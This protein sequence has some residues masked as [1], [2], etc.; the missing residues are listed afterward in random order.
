L[1]NAWLNDFGNFF[2]TADNLIKPKKQS[3]SVADLDFRAKTTFFK[4]SKINE[5]IL[6]SEKKFHVWIIHLTLSF[7]KWLSLETI[8]SNADSNLII[9]FTDSLEVVHHV[10]QY[11]FILPSPILFSLIN[12]VSLAL[13]WC[14]FLKYEANILTFFNKHLPKPSLTISYA[15]KLIVC[16]IH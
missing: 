11:N 13:A 7:N 10:L 3:P 1:W 5:R 4:G 12:C 8:S 6:K 14:E 9:E 2:K 15:I 16:A